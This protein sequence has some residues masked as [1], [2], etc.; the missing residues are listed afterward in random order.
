MI[1]CTT[2]SAFIRA[3]DVYIDFFWSV[4]VK[5]SRMC[6]VSVVPRGAPPP[7]HF[8]LLSTDQRERSYRPGPRVNIFRACVLGVGGGS[9]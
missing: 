7:Q 1:Y 8:S 2:G 5:R 3:F 6:S 9:R 4:A